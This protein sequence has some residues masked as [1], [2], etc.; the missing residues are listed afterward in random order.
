M[1]AENTFLCTDD[2]FDVSTTGIGRGVVVRC[3]PRVEYLQLYLFIG[4]KN[5]VLQ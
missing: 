3:T 1:P 2:N 4:Y 5:T